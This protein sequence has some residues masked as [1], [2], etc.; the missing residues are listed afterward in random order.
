MGSSKQEKEMTL[1]EIKRDIENLLEYLEEKKNQFER[2]Q[3]R[4]QE[5]QERLKELG[6]KT[7]EEAQREVSSLTR[8]EKVGETKI[9]EKYRKLREEVEW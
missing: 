6:L 2:E 4:L 1:D 7:L 8:K 5:K 3:G 9:R